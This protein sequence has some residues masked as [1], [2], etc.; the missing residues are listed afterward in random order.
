MVAYLITSNDM[1]HIHHWQSFVV[2]VAKDFSMPIFRHIR[3]IA[4]STSC[5]S[6][7]R[8][9]TTQLSLHRV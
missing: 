6:A 8:H 9:G 5:L 3:K 2:G 4:K 7:R 1:E